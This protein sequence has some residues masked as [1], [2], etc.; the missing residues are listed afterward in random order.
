[1]ASTASSGAMHSHAKKVQAAG[2]TNRELAF[3]D[4]LKPGPLEHVGKRTSLS[5]NYL[6][7]FC[8]L[9]ASGLVVLSLES[10]SDDDHV[11]PTSLSALFHASGDS[12]QLREAG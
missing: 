10:C 9:V 2:R 8:K 1:M 12:A 5:A 6:P 3:E 4:M 11:H 7:L